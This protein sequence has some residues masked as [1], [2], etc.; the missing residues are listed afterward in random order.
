MRE[1]LCR[2]SGSEL[3]SLLLDVFRTRA[4][5]LQPPDV[6]RQYER[7]RFVRPASEDAKRLRNLERL[8]ASLLPHGFEWLELSPLA[9]LGTTS[10]LGSVSQDWAVATA[11]GTEVL[12]DVTNLLALEAAARRKGGEGEVKLCA[13]ERV[14]R[15]QTPRAGTNLAHFRLFGLCTAGRGEPWQ[16]WESRNA[17][18]HVDFYLRLLD[19]LGIEDVQIRV[20]GGL[21]LELPAAADDEPRPYYDSGWFSIDVCGLNVVDGGLVDW[22]RRALSNRKERLLISG[23]GIDRIASLAAGAE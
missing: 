15:P 3:T 1:A 12:S 20:G 7:D 23:T 6:L 19:T 16:A 21:Q 4:A 8:G 18:E 5:R 17:R 14:V 9:P 11:R 13:C 10:V 2:L 22:T